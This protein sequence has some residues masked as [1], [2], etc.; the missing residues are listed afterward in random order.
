[1]RNTTTGTNYEDKIKY[2]IETNT[3]HRVRIRYNI[4]KK[5]NG[6]NHI[7]DILLNEKELISLK[8]QKTGGTAEEK[9]PFEVIKLQEAIDDY[10]YEKATIVLAGEDKAWT[11]KE[12]Y[13]SGDFMKYLNCPSVRII[14]HEQFINEYI[15]NNFIEETNSTVSEAVLMEWFALQNNN[16]D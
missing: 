15:G 16:G 4:G 14:S 10:H 7:V 12:Y 11:L 6:G 9:I 13:L 5:R 2:L 1:M 3:N 8:Y